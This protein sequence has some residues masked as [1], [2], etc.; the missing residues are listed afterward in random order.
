MKSATAVPAW[1]RQWLEQWKR[2]G[3][4]LARE[5]KRALRGMTDDEALAASE[6]VLALADPSKLSSSRRET[7]GLVEQQALFHSNSRK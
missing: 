2:A 4:E 1:H 7:S 6:A 3:V 5:R